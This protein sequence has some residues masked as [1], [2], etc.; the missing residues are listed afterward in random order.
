[1]AMMQIPLTDDEEASVVRAAEK[2][3]MTPTDFLRRVVL[4]VIGE[5]M[6][7][8][9]GMRTV[10]MNLRVEAAEAELVKGKAA[11]QRL[12]VSEFIRRA[13][14]GATQEVPRADA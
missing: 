8:R 7:L 12:T 3:E 2:A 1:M 4:V 10:Q 9:R 6:A 13:V 11:E 5:R 14:L